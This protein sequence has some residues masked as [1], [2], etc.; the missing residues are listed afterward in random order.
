MGLAWDVTNGVDIDLDASCVWLDSKLQPIDTVWFQKL[1]S[2]DGA[3]KHGGDEREGDEEGDDESI[4]FDLERVSP[5]ATY[6]CF[7]INSYSG[8]LLSNVASAKCHLY[9][10][11]TLNEIASFDLTGN[12]QLNSTALLMCILYR[13]GN[14]EWFMYAVG[15]SADGRT[16]QDNV[17]EFQDFLTK[18]PLAQI[19]TQR[20]QQMN[21]GTNGSG[22]KVAK[23]KV[24]ASTGPNNTVGFKLPSGASEQVTLPT[25]AKEGDT[26]EVPLIDVFIA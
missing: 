20:E 9:N 3:M 15:E 2:R 13:A 21:H 17:D 5:L 10:S 12:G 18:H 19:S 25:N 6:L 11:N 14:N 1:K 7:C 24:P 23:I 26:V 16:V 8:Q 22:N 4:M